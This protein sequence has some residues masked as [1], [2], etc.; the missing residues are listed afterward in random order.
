MKPTRRAVVGDQRSRSSPLLQCEGFEVIEGLIDEP[1]RQRLIQCFEDSGVGAGRR[2][3]LRLDA[4]RQ[5]GRDLVTRALIQ[6]RLGVGAFAVRGILFDKT[7]EANWVVAWHQDTT[8]PVRTRIDVAGF[9]SWSEKDGVPNARPPS[10][11]LESMLA[12]RVELDGSD[13][14]NAP[15]RVIPR[16][17]RRGILTRGEI[18]RTCAEHAPVECLVPTRGALL[19]KP[20]LLHSSARATEP[21]HRRVVHLEFA[22][23]PLPGGLQWHTMMGGTESG[24]GSIPG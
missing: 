15:L 6:D 9:S 24:F 16:S 19:M 22:S 21:G 11:V 2:D 14:S 4:V 3:G 20:L 7:P 5:L 13:A 12:V 23:N 10:K 18:E 8:I 1:T 17:H